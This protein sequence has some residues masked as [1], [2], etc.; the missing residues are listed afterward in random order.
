M[1]MHSRSCYYI[2]LR[3]SNRRANKTI[4]FCLLP[5]C[6]CFIKLSLSLSL[7]VSLKSMILFPNDPLLV[8]GVASFCI[9]LRFS[10]DLIDDFSAAS[11]KSADDDE[12]KNNDDE[13]VNVNENVN[14]GENA[15][16]DDGNDGNDGNGNDHVKTSFLAKARWLFRKLSTS[17]SGSTEDETLLLPS[18]PTTATTTNIKPPSSSTSSTSSSSSNQGVVANSNYGTLD[19]AIDVENQRDNA[20]ANSI[21]NSIANNIKPKSKLE[22]SIPPISLSIHLLLFAYFFTTTIFVGIQYSPEYANAVVLYG[23]APLACVSFA[24]LLGILMNL[25][26]YGR[27]RFGMFQRV[28]YTSSSVLFLFGCFV[29]LLHGL[30]DGQRDGLG[31]GQGG[32][33]GLSKV[34]LTTCIMLAI[35]AL[36]AFAECRI[37]HYPMEVD[38]DTATTDTTT[39]I[40][41]KKQKAKLTTSALLTILKPYFWPHA[42]STSATLN[43]LRAITTWFCVLLSKVCSIGAPIFIGKASTA[44]TRLEYREAMWY[45]VYYAGARLGSSVFKECQGLLYL[46]VAQAAFVELSEGKCEREEIRRVRRNKCV[47][48]GRCVWGGGG[49]R[50]KK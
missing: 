34:D 38:E 32:L 35:Y 39:K 6:T 16:G 7:S 4:L 36:L 13:N 28:M 46:F 3:H 5:S 21:A 12:K 30:G 43:R 42:T 40:N 8:A 29:P 2:V 22:S 44:L 18:K 41:K 19:T 31:D 49:V 50:K 37:C 47:C 17:N 14:D 9:V 10:S 20:I 33:E 45:S 26:D 24:A 1:H 27:R 23:T 25:R 15:G 48:G 11:Q